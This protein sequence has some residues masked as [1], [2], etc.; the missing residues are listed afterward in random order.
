MG[1]VDPPS[2]CPGD[3]ADLAARVVAVGLEA[4]LDAVGVTT[5]APL[6]DTRAA[7]V[8]RKA[9]GLHGGMAFTYRRP[10]R[11]TDPRRV[12]PSARAVVAGAWAYGHGDVPPAPAGGPQGR[13]ARYAWGAH[14]QELSA[15]LEQQQAALAVPAQPGAL[16]HRAVDEVVLVDDHH[17][18]P[19]LGPEEAGD[20]LERVGQLLVVRRRA[21]WR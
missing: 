19:A 9:A 16:G 13:V 14:Y 11:S 3:D 20:A 2:P 6:L 17:G 10:E 5:A 21:G 7:L 1:P 4:G 12:L 18:P 15:A 8:E